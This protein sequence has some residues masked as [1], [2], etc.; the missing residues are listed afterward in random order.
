MEENKTKV[1]Y[2][3]YN[4]SK[5]Y[6]LIN[7]I[8]DTFYIGSTTA[9]LSKRLSWHKK[10]S[11]Q[12]PN[13]KL[14]QHMNEIGRDNFKIILIEEHYLD[15]KEQLLREE[16]RVIQ[17]YLHDENCLNSNRALLSEE[18][19]KEN[20]R[21]K[22]KLYK[23]RHK[24]HISEYNK[25]YRLENLENIRERQQNNKKQIF[26]CICGVILTCG[27]KLNH[28]KSKNHMNKMHNLK[29]ESETI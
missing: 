9:Q 25:K 13:T 14:Y 3:R 22:C 27:A 8:D 18:D 26:T 24:D 21:K 17:M 29:Q 6:K 19:K 1:E 11:I 5:I 28:L 15:N 23:S 16:D 20:D 4:N 12:T 7:T 10:L 2:N